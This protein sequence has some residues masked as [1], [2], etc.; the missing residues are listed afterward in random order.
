MGKRWRLL[1]TGRHVV[2]AYL[3][4]VLAVCVYVGA[5]EYRVTRPSRE[6]AQEREGVQR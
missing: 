2:T 5:V 3:L 6:R 4:G 1:A